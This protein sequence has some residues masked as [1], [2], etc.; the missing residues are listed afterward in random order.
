MADDSAHNSDDDAQ[1]ANTVSSWETS[2]S[3][4][5][6]PIDDTGQFID[7]PIAPVISTS[8]RILPLPNLL[9]IHYL[10]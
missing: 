6:L 7:S 10:L 2:L 3:R 4:I 5:R 9:A 1:E 8:I